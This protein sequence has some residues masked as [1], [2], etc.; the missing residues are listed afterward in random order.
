MGRLRFNRHSDQSR[1]D[2]EF[3]N[4]DENKEDKITFA[5]RAPTAKDGGRLWIDRTGPTW[6]FRDQ[7]TGNWTSI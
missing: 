5:D 1:V 2:Q 6:Y 3:K 4:L 7:T